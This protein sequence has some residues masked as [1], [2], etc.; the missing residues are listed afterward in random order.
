MARSVL[1]E[2][3]DL[4]RLLDSPTRFSPA[5]P[6]PSPI[7]ESFDVLATSPEAIRTYGSAL[8]NAEKS[9]T[10]LGRAIE[11]AEEEMEAALRR[12]TDVHLNQLKQKELELQVR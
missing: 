7:E 5:R 3:E 1:K 12:T 6:A 11:A 10:R 8:H 9:V 4:R 2:L